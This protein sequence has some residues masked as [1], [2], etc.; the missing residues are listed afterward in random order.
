MESLVIANSRLR[1]NEKVTLINWSDECVCVTTISNGSTKQ[2]CASYAIV[3]FS[4]G[5]LQS[6][7]VNTLFEPDL[8][9]SKVDVINKFSMAHYLKIFAEFPSMFWGSE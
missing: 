1:L 7:S 6:P 2:Y 8:P 3:T 5:V 4:I 9:Q